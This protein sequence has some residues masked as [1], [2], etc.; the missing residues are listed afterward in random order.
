MK[1]RFLGMLVYF[2]GKYEHGWEKLRDVK[3]FSGPESI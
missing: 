2:P 3:W 1:E